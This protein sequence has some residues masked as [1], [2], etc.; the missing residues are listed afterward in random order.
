MF[1]L[2][3]KVLGPTSKN[4]LFYEKIQNSSKANKRLSL[5][6]SELFYCQESKVTLVLLYAAQIQRGEFSTVLHAFQVLCAASEMC[7]CWLVFVLR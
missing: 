2:I 4:Y 1:Q 3:Y 5:C 7:C 6:C